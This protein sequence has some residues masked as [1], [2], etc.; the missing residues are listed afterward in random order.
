MLAAVPTANYQGTIHDLA[1]IEQHRD[2]VIQ[3]AVEYHNGVTN[4][5]IQTRRETDTA[6]ATKRYLKDAQSKNRSVHSQIEHDKS[7]LD[8]L[9]KEM[10]KQLAKQKVMIDICWVLGAT[11]VVYLL[12]SS[13]SFVHILAMIVLV[14]GFGYVLLYNAYRVHISSDS[15]PS[16]VSPVAPSWN[17]ADWWKT[18]PS[19]DSNITQGLDI[20]KWTST[21][22]GQ[23]PTSND[24]PSPDISAITSPK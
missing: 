11:L 3:N 22:Q 2:Y 24:L 15:H 19:F 8:T 18:P 21:I 6:N 20:S 16:S 17:P 12:F 13:F 7:E 10:R 5:M 14:G 4:E 23:L 1:P 9:T